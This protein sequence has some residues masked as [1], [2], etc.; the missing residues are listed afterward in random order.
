MFPKHLPRHHRAREDGSSRITAHG[1]HSPV[2]Q[3]FPSWPGDRNTRPTNTDSLSQ[4]APSNVPRPSPTAPHGPRCPVNETGDK[5]APEGTGELVAVFRGTIFRPGTTLPNGPHH[6]SLRTVVTPRRGRVS[7]AYALFDGRSPPRGWRSR[8]LTARQ[9]K[10][11]AAIVS[12]RRGPAGRGRRRAAAGTA[13]RGRKQKRAR[14]PCRRA[15][16][17]QSCPLAS[18]QSCPLA[19]VVRPRPPG[20]ARRRVSGPPSGTGRCTP[21]WPRRRSRRPPWGPARCP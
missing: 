7:Y 20:S 6:A 15:R 1:Q 21:P 10:T 19:S 3:L 9:E 2:R 13:R 11:P 4:A 14:R 18:V 12:H 16:S 5:Y 8:P 17:L